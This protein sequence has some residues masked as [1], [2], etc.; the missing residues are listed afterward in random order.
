MDFLDDL[1]GC[2]GAD[3]TRGKK[4]CTCGR[5]GPYVSEIARLNE[6]LGGDDKITCAGAQAAHDAALEFLARL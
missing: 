3:L 2:H 5:Q 4:A 1:D 6:Q